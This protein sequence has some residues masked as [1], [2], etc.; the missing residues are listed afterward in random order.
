MLYQVE[1][2]S[3]KWEKELFSFLNGPA[4]RP[5]KEN[6]PGLQGYRERP[7][8]RP[9]E[10]IFIAHREGQFSGCA[11]LTHEAGIRRVIA[12]VFVFPR[13]RGCGM[14]TRLM[15]RIHQRACELEA[16]KIH[17]PVFQ[18]NGNGKNFLLRKGFV[19]VKDFFEMEM[20]KPDENLSFPPHIRIEPFSSGEA[21]ALARLQNRIFQGS[22][23]FNP[24]REEDIR[25]YMKILRSGWNDVLRFKKDG[26]EAGYIWT[27]PPEKRGKKKTGRVH[28]CGLLKESR[29]QGLSQALVAAGLSHLARLGADSVCLTVEAGNGPAQKLYRS[30]GFKKVRRI[31]WF[32]KKTGIRPGF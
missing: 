8:C 17:V 27:V 22:W 24:N 26:K 4:S 30:L 15:D 23:G 29:G 5:E 11:A 18:R 28:M 2:Y 25:Y 3:K 16:E 6:F 1:P 7:G 9:E 13:R 32:E 31:V 20:S 21:G 10:D 19:P 12:D 14:G